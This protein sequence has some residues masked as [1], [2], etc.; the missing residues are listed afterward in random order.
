MSHNQEAVSWLLEHCSSDLSSWEV[1]FLE[2]LDGR[3]SLTPKQQAKLDEIWDDV[4]VE[5]R[6]G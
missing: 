4:V 3:I 6:R 5:K 1:D 2:S